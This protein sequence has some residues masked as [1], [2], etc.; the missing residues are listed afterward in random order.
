MKVVR[1]AEQP[2]VQAPAENFT[3]K[4]IQKIKIGDVI[5]TPPSVKHWH[6]ASSAHSMTHAA[7]T[8]AVDGKTVEWLERVTEDQYKLQ[9]K[10]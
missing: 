10:Q 2:S 9:P 5:W 1:I 7:I 3:G 8:E 4:V 6:G